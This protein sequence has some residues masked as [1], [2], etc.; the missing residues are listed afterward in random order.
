[1][2]RLAEKFAEKFIEGNNPEDRKAVYRTAKFSEKWARKV[3]K[4]RSAES[5][6]R[7][8][9]HMGTRV[10]RWSEIRVH[11]SGERRSVPRHWQELSEEIIQL[12]GFRVRMYLEYLSAQSFPEW[13]DWT[14]E[15]NAH[16]MARTM[17]EARKISSQY[18]VVYSRY[19]NG[20]IGS[21]RFIITSIVCIMKHLFL[22]NH[23]FILRYLSSTTNEMQQWRKQHFEPF[24][25]S[26]QKFR[27]VDN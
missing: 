11:V 27:S 9:H 16:P 6:G 14:K 2:I 13:Q 21:K 19:K 25:E 3:R 15:S 22:I 4:R 24:R 17:M 12:R 18:E 7:R 23:A 10:F 26:I 5:R 1:M 8:S 20:L